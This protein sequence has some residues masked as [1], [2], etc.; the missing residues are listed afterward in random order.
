[1]D[2]FT[3]VVTKSTV[4]VGTG[5]EVEA[6]VARGAPTRRWRWSP[7]RSSCARA[8]P[9]R[10]SSA[11]TGWWWARD[12]ERARE[13]MRELYRPLYLNETPILFTAGA[14]PS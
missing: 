13:V 3:V 14:P 7:T 4:P 10:T 5:D 12:D 8:R 1:M 9:S 11:P 2:G 6:I